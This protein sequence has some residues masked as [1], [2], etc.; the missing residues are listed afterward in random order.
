MKKKAL[1]TVLSLVL[2]AAI[3]VVGTLAFLQSKTDTVENTFT[4]GHVKIE[5]RESEYDPAK[6]EMKA[7]T[8]EVDAAKTRKNDTYKLI[9]GRELP[10]DPTVRV[11]ANSETS[12]VFVK[13]EKVNDPD[14]YLD[15][16][17]ADGWT[18][19][20]GVEG[21]YYREYTQNTEKQDYSVLKENKVTVK[22]TVTNEM[23]EEIG[24]NKPQLKFTAYAIQKEGL[25]SV[26]A[27]WTEVS[28]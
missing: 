22:N 17:I 15:Y 5:L 13:V 21:V 4:V 1:L 10:K 24:D 12:W 19:L 27:A 11:L 23:L 18:A 7:D 20:E 28:N 8:L 9:P 16:T 25:D 14:T 2:V 3:S 6:N 26:Q